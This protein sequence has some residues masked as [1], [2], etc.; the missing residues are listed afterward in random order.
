M[1]AK[2][3]E[4]PAERTDIIGLREQT[5]TIGHTPRGRFG[6]GDAFDS[7]TH[8]AHG[9][10]SKS[11]F[12]PR[13]KQQFLILAFLKMRVVSISE[14]PRPPAH[15]GGMSQWE[16]PPWGSTNF[17]VPLGYRIQTDYFSRT[18]EQDRAMAE[19][20]NILVSIEIVHLSL[21]ALRIRDVISIHPRD[22]FAA[23]NFYALIESDSQPP[24]F[25]SLNE[26]NPRIPKLANDLRS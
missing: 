13:T 5:S 6:S 17:L 19:K 10:H 26:A 20:I 16:P 8:Q 3:S 25:L 15:P 1:H 4:R 18:S 2:P 23:R 24:A 7:V 22:V 9:E 12:A 14:K 11:A 21:K